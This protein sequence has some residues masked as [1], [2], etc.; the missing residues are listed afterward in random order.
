MRQ[1]KALPFVKWVGG[2]R[3]ILQLLIDRLPARFKDYYEPFVGG[4][5]LYYALHR[6]LEKAYLSDTNPDLTITYNTIRQNPYPLLRLLEVHQQNHSKDYYYQIRSLHSQEDPATI[7]ARLLYLNRTCFNGLYRENLKGHFNVPIGRYKNP[8]I[9]QRT[10]IAACNLALQRARIRL[11][12]FCSITPSP[13]DFVY[14]DP[15]YHPVS[16]T[17]FTS[18]TKLNFLE[19]DQ[20]RLRDFALTLHNIGTFTMISNSDT[21]L[22]RELYSNPP[23]KIESIKSL[24]SVSSKAES[25]GTTSELLIRT[26]Q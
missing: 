16:L 3:S 25:R 4:G 6:R 5:A 9:V 12:D 7:A 15:P 21:P 8:D 19:A 23:F 11:G 1:T 2:K 17:S 13:G 14:C 20:T 18:Y 26:Y 10:N 24:R 22:I